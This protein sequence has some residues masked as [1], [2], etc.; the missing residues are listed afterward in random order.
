MNI[1][2]IIKK[3]ENGEKPKLRKIDKSECI[4]DSGKKRAI[5]IKG[6]DY[7]HIE[8]DVDVDEEALALCMWYT[9]DEQDDDEQLLGFDDKG[10]QILG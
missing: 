9:M 7:F 2:E 1:Q 3:M 8:E 6:N 10:C 4:A 5:L